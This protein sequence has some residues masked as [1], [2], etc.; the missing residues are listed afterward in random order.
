VTACMHA[1]ICHMGMVMQTCSLKADHASGA[2]ELKCLTSI[3]VRLHT[4]S[5]AWLAVANFRVAARAPLTGC[6]YLQGH[7]MTCN[8]SRPVLYESGVQQSLQ[9][10]FGAHKKDPGILPL[11]GANWP[12]PVQRQVSVP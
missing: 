7:L 3:A 8:Q 11:Q 6:C 5:R 2:L 1:Y 4:G 12:V 10:F 9:A